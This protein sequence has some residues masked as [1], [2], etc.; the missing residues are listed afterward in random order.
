MSAL[1]CFQLPISQHQQLVCDRQFVDD[2]AD[3]LIVLKTKQIEVLH[4][5]VL[6]VMLWQEYFCKND[7]VRIDYSESRKILATELIGLAQLVP[8]CANKVTISVLG[9]MMDLDSVIQARAQKTTGTLKQIYRNGVTSCSTIDQEYFYHILNTKHNF[10]CM[11]IESCLNRNAK[12]K[13]SFDRIIQEI[14]MLEN[15][16][17]DSLHADW[18]QFSREIA[19][20]CDYFNRLQN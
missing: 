7:S 10:G 4:V 11:S 5:Y 20:I 9:S 6:R 3:A 1:T 14:K 13:H 15:A 2:L 8:N 16:S 19:Y 12:F 17:K 18:S